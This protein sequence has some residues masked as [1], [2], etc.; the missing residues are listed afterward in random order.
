MSAADHVFHSEDLCRLLFG[1]LLF[2]AVF[3]SKWLTY[4]VTQSATACTTLACTCRG[5]RDVA[6]GMAVAPVVRHLMRQLPTGRL[7]LLM[8]ADSGLSLQHAVTSSRDANERMNRM[9][10][11]LQETT[12][13]LSC[14]ANHC[15]LNQRVRRSSRSSMRVTSL[16][17]SPWRLWSARS[18]RTGR[19]FWCL[20]DS[21]GTMARR[22]SLV[23]DNCVVAS[24]ELPA[25]FADVDMHTTLSERAC[26]LCLSVDVQQQGELSLKQLLVYE[27]QG[28]LE[29]VLLNDLQ[30]HFRGEV[31]VWRYTRFVQLCSD[32][33]KLRVLAVWNEPHDCWKSAVSS[34]DLETGELDNEI[35]PY[36]GDGTVEAL[37]TATTN[38]ALILV[39]VFPS[40]RF[41]LDSLVVRLLKRAA[42]GSGVVQTL[43]GC[44]TA[45]TLMAARSDSYCV[46]CFDGGMHFIAQQSLASGSIFTATERGVVSQVCMSY[47]I[48]P[49]TIHKITNFEASDDGSCLLFRSK[50]CGRHTLVQLT[51]NPRA[52]MESSLQPRLMRCDKTVGRVEFGSPGEIVVHRNTGGALVLS[53]SKEPT[54]APSRVVNLDAQN[55]YTCPYR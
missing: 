40:Q 18:R 9:I 3:D 24:L 16:A 1:L 43:S 52:S 21:D 38:D 26:V 47:G 5:A 54:S 12:S 41:C 36:Y 14:C 44:G 17:P 28:K 39:R 49:D 20:G 29:T 45:D 7:L 34:V 37:T 42:D 35:N 51:N 48:R 13:P 27:H 8:L 22:V 19:S 11:S 32:E 4:R 6:R 55:D 23:R 33:S 46:A 10:R 30:R 53:A 50:P 25:H 31:L 15:C 2:D